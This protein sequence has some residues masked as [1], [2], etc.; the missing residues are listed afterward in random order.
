MML[1][2]VAICSNSN[3]QILS[4]Q[5][6]A[7]SRSKLWSQLV[8]WIGKVALLIPQSKI[9]R[10][11]C[12][13]SLQGAYYTLLSLE[14][15]E[16]SMVPNVPHSKTQWPLNVPVCSDVWPRSKRTYLFIRPSLSFCENL[17]FFVLT[18]ACFFIFIYIEHQAIYDI[19]ALL[20][21]N[22]NFKSTTYSIHFLAKAESPPRSLHLRSPRHPS[23]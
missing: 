16:I 17:C 1:D 12:W 23:D 11:R 18:S 7:T 20:L 15:G 5:R 2:V 22:S 3:S 4:K 8:R 6:R 10:T 21:M 9:R 14:M 19:C 13:K